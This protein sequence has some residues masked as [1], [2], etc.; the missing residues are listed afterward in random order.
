MASRRVGRPACSNLRLVILVICFS[1]VF[2]LAYPP[3]YSSYSNARLIESND[4]GTTT[5]AL[6]P[7]GPFDPEL[8]LGRQGYNVQIQ[9]LRLVS[10]SI[11]SVRFA[12]SFYS[13]V[14]ESALEHIQGGIGRWADLRY[15]YG[16]IYLSFKGLF[17]RVVDWEMIYEFAKWMRDRA[18]LGLVGLYRGAIWNVDG[19]QYVRI[20]FGIMG[21]DEKDTVNE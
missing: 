4:D 21:M 2:S 19:E 5:N 10:P 8:Q 6:S 14:M 20:V 16:E 17:T 12:I 15:T 9:P 3:L 11:S 13:W 18:E 7:R 1:S